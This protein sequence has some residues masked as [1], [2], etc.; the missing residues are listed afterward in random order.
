MKPGAIVINCARGA[1]LDEAALAA[2]LDRGHLGAAGIDVFEVEPAPADHP[3]FG[4][5]DVVVTPHSAGT[6]EDALRRTA[7]MAAQNILDCFDGTLKR[8][9]VFNPQVLE[10]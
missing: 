6:S 10:P 4:R 7:E 9:N 5:D 1:V 8:E 3:L 2:A